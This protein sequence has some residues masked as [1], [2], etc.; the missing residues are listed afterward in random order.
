MRV[1]LA[2][3][4]FFLSG[5]IAGAQVSS[6]ADPDKSSQSTGRT[7]TPEEKGQLQPQG[8]TGPIEH[9]NL[10]YYCRPAAGLTSL[11]TDDPTMRWLGT[12]AIETNLPVAPDVETMPA[13]LADDVRALALDAL[14]VAAEAHSS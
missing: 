10:V 7:V 14:R 1:M 9:I 4:C 13:A 8:W 6:P 5:G 2:A 3:V 11:R 12:A